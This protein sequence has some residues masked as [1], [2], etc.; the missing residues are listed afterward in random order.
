M[1]RRSSADDRMGTDFGDLRIS[2]G[3]PGSEPNLPHQRSCSAIFMER[4][5]ALEDAGATPRVSLTSLTPPG[6]GVR[7]D[8]SSLLKQA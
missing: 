5:N 6:C 8:P 4:G 3:S 1:T 7:L 2:A